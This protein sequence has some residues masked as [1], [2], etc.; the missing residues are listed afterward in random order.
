MK[1]ILQASYDRSAG[2]YDGRFRELQRVKYAAMLGA[3]GARL[4]GPLRRGR[5]LDLG[6]GTG[7]LAE[8]LRAGGHDPAGSLV[9]LDLSHAMV[10]QARARGLHAVQGDLD[11]L[12]FRAA[13]FAAAVAFTALRIAPGPDARALTEAARVLVPGGLFVVTVLERNHDRSFREELAAAGFEAGAPRAC[14]QDVGYVCTRR[15][16]P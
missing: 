7:L 1:D 14:G 12:P 11:H 3:D 13:S 16:G 5:V 9:A 2:D 10:L 8:F 15:V 6:A 4:A